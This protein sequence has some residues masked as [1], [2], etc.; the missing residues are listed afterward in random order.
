MPNGDGMGVSVL[1][2]RK[3]VDIVRRNLHVGQVFQS[4]A[5]SQTFEAGDDAFR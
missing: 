2:D 3:S 5:S 4:W 1:T